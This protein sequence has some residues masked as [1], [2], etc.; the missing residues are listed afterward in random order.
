MTEPRTPGAE[1]HTK[2]AAAIGLLKSLKYLNN[3][4]TRS[5]KGIYHYQF[6]TVYTAARQNR[7]DEWELLK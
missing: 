6:S 3:G 4:V 1:K 7:M 5:F 2:E